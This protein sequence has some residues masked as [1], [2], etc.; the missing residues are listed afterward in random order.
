MVFGSIF[1]LTPY[2]VV[3]LRVQ[4]TTKEVSVVD[5]VDTT[6]TNCGIF[7]LWYAHDVK[8]AS[9][10]YMRANGILSPSNNDKYSP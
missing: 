10:W 3:C 1:V 8:V 9:T 5:V 6:L 4:G 7:T 2:C